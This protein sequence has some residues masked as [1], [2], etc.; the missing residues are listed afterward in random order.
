[1][2]CAK[3]RRVRE[4][5]RE[6]T[7]RIYNTTIVHCGHTVISPFMTEDDS[8]GFAFVTPASALPFRLMSTAPPTG[9]A[10]YDETSPSEADGVSAMDILRMFSFLQNTANPSPSEK[11]PPG[12]SLATRNT[13]HI[14]SPNDV[15]RT[16]W[17]KV[18][19]LLNTVCLMV[20]RMFGL[21]YRVQREK[22]NRLDGVEHFE[23]GGH[24]PDSFVL[25]VKGGTSGNYFDDEINPGIMD[26]ILEDRVLERAHDIINA[27]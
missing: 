26:S 5:E 22:H 13:V 12:C 10:H 18:I 19:T 15:P 17:G 3:Y 4:R 27:G 11:Y 14:P 23:C 25:T 6:R 20:T 24:T 1:M 7:N 16:T 9:T 2:T 8:D 21:L